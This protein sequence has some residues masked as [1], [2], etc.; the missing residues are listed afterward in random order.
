MQA[1][2]AKIADEFS[3]NFFLQHVTVTGR[4]V[5][6]VIEGMPDAGAGRSACCA[7]SSDCPR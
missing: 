5:G 1:I 3:R 6:L 4:K 7:S 2:G